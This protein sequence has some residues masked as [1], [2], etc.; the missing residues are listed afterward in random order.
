MRNAVWILCLAACGG[1][2]ASEPAE[3]SPPSPYVVDVP[4][5]VGETPALADVERALQQG[6][7]AALDLDPGPVHA[8]Y[9][10][11]MAGRDGSC[12]YE[13]VTP[14][15]NYW[16]DSCDAGSGA[17]YDGYV[18]AYEAAG[19]PDAYTPGF[20]VD[21]WAAFGGAVVTDAAGHTLEVSGSVTD[22]HSY[23]DS[24][25]VRVDTWYRDLSGTFRWDGPEA[26]GTWLEGD[27]DPD[28]FTYV[29]VLPELGLASVYLEGGYSGLPGG[30]AVGFDENQLGHEGIGF[31]CEREA[32]GTM[33]VRSP[34][35]TWVDVRFDGAFTAAEL[36]PGACDGCGTAYAGG[37]ELGEVCVSLDGILTKA[38]TP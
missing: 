14:D 19:L 29:S 3:P 6:L 24:D 38:V 22:Y 28:L 26:R 15:G 5:A 9:A 32:T 4:G 17:S 37:V 13:Y 2:G 11:A 16:F 27:Y 23:G 30:W 7:D 18:F 34:E 1:S 35:G 20:L 33:S 25:G 36:E 12:P 10:A 31:P 21:Y 8:A